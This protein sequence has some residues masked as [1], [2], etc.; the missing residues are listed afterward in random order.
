[1]DR[2]F[3]RLNPTARVALV[4]LASAERRNPADQAALMI[5][6][7]LASVTTEQEKERITP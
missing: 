5:E 3:V 2:V 6:R 7:A 4:Q 1:M